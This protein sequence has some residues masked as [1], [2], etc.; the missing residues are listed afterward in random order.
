VSVEELADEL[1]SKEITSDLSLIKLREAKTWP[2]R[3]AVMVGVASG[4]FL[5]MGVSTCLFLVTRN[6]LA[7][8]P[9]TSITVIASVVVASASRLL[10]WSPEDYKLAA[11]KQMV[12]MKQWEYRHQER[13]KPKR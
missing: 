5:G 13:S 11:L 9:L 8:I 4:M 1:F 6:E 7:F 2:M 12:K 10:F 3:W